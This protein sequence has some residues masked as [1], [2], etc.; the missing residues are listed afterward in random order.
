MLQTSTE[1]KAKNT[2]ISTEDFERRT[3]MRCSAAVRHL[4][5]VIVSKMAVHPSVAI[6]AVVVPS[7]QQSFL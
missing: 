1:T 7:P 2:R 5:D 4:N 3:V 6:P